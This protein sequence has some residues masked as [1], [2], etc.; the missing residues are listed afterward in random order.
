V[1]HRLSMWKKKVV[2]ISPLK[3][4]VSFNGKGQMKS[5]A[6]VKVGKAIKYR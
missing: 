6:C 3:V 5:I 1:E 4:T 2:D